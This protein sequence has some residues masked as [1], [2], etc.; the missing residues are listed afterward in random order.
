[1][2]SHKTDVC[3]VS[4]HYTGW[5]TAFAYWSDDGE[6]LCEFC[7]LEFACSGF[8]LQSRAFAG[9]VLMI[10]WP[11]DQDL[12]FETAIKPFSDERL[13]LNGEL[14]HQVS[15]ERLPHG[16]NAIDLLVDDTINRGKMYVSFYLPTSITSSKIPHE[17]FT[18]SIKPKLTSPSRI[19]HPNTYLPR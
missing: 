13:C 12:L 14:F 10:L 9:L 6:C 19:Q 17:D 7:I 3:P 16:W 8:T 11:S 4:D 15:A 2:V 18:P 5:I 1:M